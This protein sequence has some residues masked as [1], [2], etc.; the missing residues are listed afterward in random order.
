MGN[1]FLDEL[2][3]LFGQQSTPNNILNQNEKNQL[4]DPNEILQQV[5]TENPGL[6]KVHNPKNTEVMFASP[7]RKLTGEKMG[8]LEY[9]P[10]EET[11]TQG[12]EHPTGGGKNVLEIY[13]DQLQNNPD[14]LKNAIYGDLIHGMNKDSTWKTMRNDFKKSYT[15]E[16]YERLAERQSWW[17]DANGKD[18]KD[19]AIHDAYIRGWMNERDV[20]M[21]GQ[22]E[23]GGTMYSKKQLAILKR[24]EKY[25][26]TGK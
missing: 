2:L 23:Y 11:G 6:A 12:W 25:L 7:S 19:M 22:K 20:A 3:K 9:W 8:G 16:E 15:P 13:S 21:Q 18:A 10:A 5:L 14:A 1:V 17:E 24:M 4:S 26:K